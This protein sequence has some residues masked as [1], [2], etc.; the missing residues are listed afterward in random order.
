MSCT[1]N[2]IIT[3]IYQFDPETGDFSF[4]FNP[5]HQ[6]WVFRFTFSE[7]VLVG[8]TAEGLTT[9]KLLQMNSEE[10]LAEREKLRSK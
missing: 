1:D 2:S 7:V 9:I 4:L 10:R 3:Q 8:L 6:E 5:R